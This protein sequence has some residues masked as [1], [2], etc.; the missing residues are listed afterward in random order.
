[1]RCKNGAS[2]GGGCR[3]NIWGKEKPS[4]NGNGNGNGKDHNKGNGHGHGH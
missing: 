1:M 2:C 3:N 4:N